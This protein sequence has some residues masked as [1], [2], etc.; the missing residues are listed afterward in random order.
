MAIEGQYSVCV[1]H[2]EVPWAFPPMVQTPVLS[3]LDAEA[4][5]RI[6]KFTRATRKS[7]TS[8]TSKMF[9]GT[10]LLMINGKGWRAYRIVQRSLCSCIVA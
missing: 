8:D 5:E 1:E 7:T 4:A 2:A 9:G 10:G 6:L 3:V